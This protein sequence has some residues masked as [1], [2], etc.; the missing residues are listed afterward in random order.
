MIGLHVIMIA[1]L[2]KLFKLEINYL[3]NNKFK[4]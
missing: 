3:N 1:Q 2:F 4:N